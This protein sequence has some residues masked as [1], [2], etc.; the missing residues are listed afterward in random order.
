M[1]SFSQFFLGSNK[2]IAHLELLEIFHPSFS[3]LYRVVR[4]ARKGVTVTLEDSTVALFNFQPLKITNSGARDDLDAGI[5][6]SFGDLGKLLPKEIERV[7]QDDSFAIKPIVIYRTYRSDDLDNVLL[8]PYR[9]EIKTLTQNRTGA[10][11]E[12]AAPGLNFSK[13]GELYRIDRFIALRGFL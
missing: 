9:F 13:T 7:I 2:N 6:V 5:K 4:N 3:Q 1:S 10:T 11:F 12:A 8:G